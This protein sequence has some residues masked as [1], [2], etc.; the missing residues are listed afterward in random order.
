[1][2]QCVNYGGSEHITRD[3]PIGIQII[4]RIRD[5]DTLQKTSTERFDDGTS[6]FDTETTLLNSKSNS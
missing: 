1:M 5:G 3:Y 2:I 4:I 6:T